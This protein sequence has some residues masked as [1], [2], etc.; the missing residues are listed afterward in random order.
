LIN[1]LLQPLCLFSQ[2][3]FKEWKEDD[4]TKTT[5]TTSDTVR[6][7][8]SLQ[9]NSIGTRVNNN[10][11]HNNQHNTQA[12][13]FIGV[14]LATV[15]AG[16]FVR[17]KATRMFRPFFL[18]ASVVV[19]G[20]Y[21][22]AC[23]CPIAGLEE[24]V[25]FFSAQGIHP[26]RALWF[27]ALIPIT[28]FLGRVW[29][30]WVCHLG[31]LQELLHF[32]AKFNFLASAKA[33]KIM[34]SIRWVVFLALVVQLLITK[35]IHWD[36]IDPFKAAYNLM[37]SSWVSWV[38]LGII[39]LTSVFMYRPF[40]K[41]V[42]PVGLVLGWISKIP[43]TAALRTKK[44]C[45]GC[46]LCSTACKMHALTYNNKVITLYKQD[47]LACGECLEACKMKALKLGPTEDAKTE[48]EIFPLKT[49]N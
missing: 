45:I 7:G 30:G 6:G 19:L 36:Q 13:W 32:P 23:P 12:Y 15:A 14:L 49:R 47:C 5:I 3:E 42:C 28:Y 34:R 22:G 46:K 9:A 11:P 41:T 43:G 39:L 24:T 33:Q 44:E 48:Y 26:I 2:D 25:L 18:V 21:R 4:S 27:L 20:F 31:A 10:T 35:T 38:L 16:I 29:C 17:Y 8:A 40:C 37:A 1:C